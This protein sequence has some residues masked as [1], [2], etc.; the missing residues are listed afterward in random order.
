MIE[1]YGDLIE[2]KKEIEI[3]LI[4]TWLQDTFEVK[5]KRTDN[6]EV[7]LGE[8]LVLFELSLYDFDTIYRTDDYFLNFIHDNYLNND[9]ILRNGSVNKLIKEYPEYADKII[10]FDDFYGKFL[11]DNSIIGSLNNLRSIL[12]NLVTNFKREQERLENRLWRL[13]YMLLSNAT[14]ND[15]TIKLKKNELAVFDKNFKAI[16]TSFAIQYAA[17]DILRTVSEFVGVLKLKRNNL[18]IPKDAINEYIRVTNSYNKNKYS[19]LDKIQEAASI[20]GLHATKRREIFSQIAGTELVYEL[21]NENIQERQAELNKA[22]DEI[23][24]VTTT[25][26][27]KKV[28]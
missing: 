4:E 1:N 24:Q 5:E 27:L 13:N 8:I 16:S 26:I 10:L 21:H 20:K 15:K 9:Y 19:E 17:I 6:Q 18:T 7:W 2:R 23:L 22:I 3:A 28:K 11:R 25:E 12:Q 14:E